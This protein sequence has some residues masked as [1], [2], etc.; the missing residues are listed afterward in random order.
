MQEA[1]QYSGFERDVVWVK[2][3]EKN[4]NAERE[5][6]PYRDTKLWAYCVLRHRQFWADQGVK[7]RLVPHFTHE[8]EVGWWFPAVWVS[9]FAMTSSRAA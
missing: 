1:K 3:F 4:P 6:K 9:D 8:G 7:R 2:R 5:N